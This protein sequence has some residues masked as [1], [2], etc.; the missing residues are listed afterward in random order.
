MVK[1]PKKT[2]SKIDKKY[3]C[4]SCDF[5]SRDKKDFRRH[6]STTKHKNGNRMIMYGTA[7]ICDCCFK[8]YKYSSGLSRHKK[9]CKKQKTE[10]NRKITKKT[11]VEAMEAER[12]KEVQNSRYV[13]N[14]NKNSADCSSN[15]NENLQTPT[16]LV[17]KLL[18][19]QNKI[20]Q[21]LVDLCKERQQEINFQ[22]CNNKRLTINVFLNEKCKNAMN[23]TEFINRLEVSLQDLDYTETHGYV[24]GIS[25]IFTKHLTHMKPTER[26][27]HCCDKKR[28]QFYIKEDDQWEKDETNVIINKSIADISVKQIK[29]LK[30]WEE[31]NPTYLEDEKLL[32][33]W[34]SL[35]TEIMGPVAGDAGDKNKEQIKKT[36][37]EKLELRDAM[38]LGLENSSDKSIGDT[39]MDPHQ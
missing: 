29:K 18:K 14:L 8:S 28:L 36:I 1:S 3:Y 24:K 10:K 5:T 9:S 34:H 31:Q 27:I 32:E 11:E 30:E 6:C 37:S 2:A 12:A 33:K 23:L 16:E 21:Q 4:K 7:Y 19:L 35:L 39:N 20:Q 22:N 15:S 25:N 26:P 13:G 17:V 38:I